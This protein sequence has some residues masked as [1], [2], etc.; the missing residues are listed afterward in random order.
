LAEQ[1]I[2]VREGDATA[3]LAMQDDQL[4]PEHGIFCFKP[5]LRLEERGNQVQQERYQR[6]HSR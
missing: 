6:D 5:A 2:A 1:P 3:H 4:M